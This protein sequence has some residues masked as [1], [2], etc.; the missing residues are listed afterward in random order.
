MSGE[1]AVCRPGQAPRQSWAGEHRKHG[2]AWALP[3]P[4]LRAR[5][6]GLPSAWAARPPPQPGGRGWLAS[7]LQQ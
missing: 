3:S 4:L 1:A 5:A 2:W 7:Q 6:P